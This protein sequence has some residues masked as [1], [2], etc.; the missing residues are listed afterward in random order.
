[1]ELS[2][3]VSVVSWV[4]QIAAAVI[5]LQTLYFKFTAAPESVYIFSALH[6]EPWGRIGSGIAEIVAAALLLVPRTTVYGALFSL[7]ITGVAI[8]S[9]LTILGVTLPAVGD[10][11]EL[12]ALAVAVFVAS[13]GVAIIHRHDLAVIGRLLASRV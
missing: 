7:V 12:F 3:S 9:H 13:A 11:G 8:L 6:T 10:R 2:R 5:L 4:L 1:M